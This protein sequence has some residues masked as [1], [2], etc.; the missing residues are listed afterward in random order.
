MYQGARSIILGFYLFAAHVF[1]GRLPGC[2][3]TTGRGTDPSSA[4]SGH[5]VAV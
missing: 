1:V 2:E 4:S 3:P 5:E